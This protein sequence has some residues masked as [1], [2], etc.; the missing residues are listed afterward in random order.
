MGVAD[1]VVRGCVEDP[2]W[3]HLRV[4][5]FCGRLNLK[6]PDGRMLFW[7]YYYRFTLKLH[8]Q[9]CLFSI[10]SPLLS[11]AITAAA[12]QGAAPADIFED[13]K[14]LNICTLIQ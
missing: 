8:E 14:T 13:D 6:L 5:K 4:R 10:K 1:V 12:A 7:S 9:A 2:E 11:R 3:S